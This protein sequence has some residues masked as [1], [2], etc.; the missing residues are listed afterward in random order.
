MSGDTFLYIYSKYSSSCNEILPIIHQ[1]SPAT[2]LIAIDADNIKIRNYLLSLKIFNSVPCII[3]SYPG[4]NRMEIYE[5]YDVITFLNKILSMLGKPSVEV[6][7]NKNKNLNINSSSIPSMRI[8]TSQSSEPVKKVSNGT[9]KTM[10]SFDTKQGEKES[11]QVS[12]PKGK[13]ALAVRIDDPFEEHRELEKLANTDPSD[14]KNVYQDRMMNSSLN[15]K[16][17]EGHENMKSSIS[18]FEDKK[19]DLSGE[20][21]FTPLDDDDYNSSENSLI[22]QPTKIN[23]NDLVGPNG[24][25]QNRELEAKQDKIKNAAAAM[26]SEREELDNAFNK[27]KGGTG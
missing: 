8:P 14:M 1:I 9:G 6:Q 24:P 20:S 25:P 15:I 12:V 11:N 27:N 17:G 7:L 22:I 3:L 18:S 5:G 21:N 13:T 2:G 23:Y 26:M 19:T 4:E 10:L 16:K